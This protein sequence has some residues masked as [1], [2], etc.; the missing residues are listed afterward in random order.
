MLSTEVDPNAGTEVLPPVFTGRA[1]PVLFADDGT[2]VLPWIDTDLLMAYVEPA[3]ERMSDDL[4]PQPDAEPK[5]LD[6]EV[7]REDA[8]HPIGQ[9]VAAISVL[10]GLAMSGMLVVALTMALATR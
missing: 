1:R 9:R 3:G 2:R 4:R 8:P 10:A 6:A 7:L 5:A